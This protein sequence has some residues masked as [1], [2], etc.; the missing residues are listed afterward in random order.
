MIEGENLDGTFYD[1]RAKASEIIQ[2]EDDIVRVHDRN[3]ESA[4]QLD[5]KE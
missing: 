1:P 3:V 5:I 4:L 2:E